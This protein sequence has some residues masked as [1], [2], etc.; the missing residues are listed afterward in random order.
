MNTLKL[1]PSK[2]KENPKNNVYLLELAVNS[3]YFC[4]LP[5]FESFPF[6]SKWNLDTG[7]IIVLM[8]TLQYP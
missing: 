2:D 5:S 6:F 1:N 3:Q 7:L 8:A 4:I